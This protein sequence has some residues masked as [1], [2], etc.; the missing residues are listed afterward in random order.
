MPAPKGC[1][2]GKNGDQSSEGLDISI[3]ELRR[4]GFFS[5]NREDRRPSG[6]GG[7][8]RWK[9]EG[10]RGERRRVGLDGCVRPGPVRARRFSGQDRV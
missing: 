9:R 4:V 7:L 10:R 3:C 6:V 1:A 8:G 2:G 5:T